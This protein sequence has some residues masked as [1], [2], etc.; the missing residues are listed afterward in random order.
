MKENPHCCF[1]PKSLTINRLG[2]REKLQFR[3]ALYFRDNKKTE[4]VIFFLFFFSYPESLF[5]LP[6]WFLPT[7]HGQGSNSVCRKV[8]PATDTAIPYFFLPSDSGVHD[9]FSFVLFAI[10]LLFK[11]VCVI[12]VP[13]ELL[14]V[15]KR[16]K[17]VSALLW[18]M[19]T[20]R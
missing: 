20:V 19:Y 18:K 8:P 4:V 12:V 2:R 13:F 11:L 6:P 9:V 5:F 1:I 3:Q 15:R 7:G 14:L 10:Q 17:S 16:E